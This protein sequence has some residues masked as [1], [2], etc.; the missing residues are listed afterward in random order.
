MFCTGGGVMKVKKYKH[1]ETIQLSVFNFEADKN[2]D[3]INVW[4]EDADGNVVL[5]ANV[6]DWDFRVPQQPINYEYSQKMYP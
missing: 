5:D 2:A 4:A 1:S 3:V 6:E